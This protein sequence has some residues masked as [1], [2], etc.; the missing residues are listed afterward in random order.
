MRRSKA[1]SRSRAR[2]RSCL[3]AG[4]LREPCVSVRVDVLEG[5]LGCAAAAQVSEEMPRPA[6]VGLPGVVVALADRLV[7]FPE[8]LHRLGGFP[9][10]ADKELAFE[11]FGFLLGCQHCCLL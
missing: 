2:R 10:L 8:L 7:R 1:T 5:E 11:G 4:L 3:P 6:G 9:L